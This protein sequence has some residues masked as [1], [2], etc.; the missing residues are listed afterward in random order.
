MTSEERT[1]RGS[2]DFLRN[3][4]SAAFWWGLPLAAGWTGE[5]LPIAAPDKTLVWAAALAW[6]GVGCALNAR[7]CRRLHCFLAAPVLLLGAAATALVAL[8]W[9]P[10]GP[11]AAGYLVNGSLGL[12]L[13][14]FLAEPV[15]GRYRTRRPRAG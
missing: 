1:G 9:T 13:L 12:A 4:L 11:I 7:R 3:P 5:A 14:T 10:L 6:M 8:G 15:W 2:A